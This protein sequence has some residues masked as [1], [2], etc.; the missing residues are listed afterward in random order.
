[1]T[2]DDTARHPGIRQRLVAILAADAAGYSRRMSEDEHG[3]LDALEAARSVFRTA[4]EG[5]NGRVIDTAGDSVLAVFET[6]K[7]ALAAAIAVQDDLSARGQGSL[8]FRVGV[9]LGDVIQKPDGT[10]YGDGVNVA[11]R[12]QAL[13]D[14]GSVLVSDLVY[15][16]LRG[17]MGAS[18]V[19]H[20]THRVKNIERPITAFRVRTAG[21][22]TERPVSEVA[23]AARPSVAV[24]PFDNMSG[25]ERETYM[26]DGLTEDLIAA[27]S[28]YRGL[29][30]IARN[31]CFA[32]KGR[33]VDV[34][35]AAKELGA[36]YV[37]E[38][39]VRKS[40]TRLRVVAQLIEG[41]SGDHL[42]A[43]RYDREL[44]DLFALQDDIV[45]MI[46][47]RLEPEVATVELQRAMR[48]PTQNLGA[49]DCY[50][51]ALSQLYRFTPDANA[52]A[53]RLFR[54]AIEF[55]ANFA[56]AHA[57]LAYCLILDMVY[58]DAPA[59]PDVL[60]EILS[61]TKKAVSLDPSDAF[62]HLA[63][64][65]AHIAR[66]EYE[67]GLA[68]C[69]A[70][71]RLNPSMGIAYCGMGDALAYAGRAQDAIE[72]FETAIRLSPNDPWRWAFYAYG[73]LTLIF[74]RRF[75]HAA[76]WAQKALLV[77]NCQYW[78]SA[79]LAVAL[80]HLGRQAEARAALANLKKMHPDFSLPYAREQ[81]F[82][83]ERAEQIELYLDGLRRAGMTG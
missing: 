71:L 75:D 46:A 78:A 13:A 9:H 26:A 45:G 82:Y 67:L 11:A 15:G 72:C 7:G 40:G 12:L 47:G 68:A 3:T 41:A 48:K 36:Q 28:K 32:Y 74:L 8:H 54:R 49:W 20:G 64:G 34:R 73:A 62:C 81:L 1:M 39:S 69:E 80:G 24:L 57:R 59:T 55:D 2:A 76:E 23:P 29:R 19:E 37:L 6:A 44:Q 53:E 70:G 25:D 66:R 31:S 21:E 14:P 60:D 43:E 42:W 65:R 18:F 22:L 30:V 33:A 5:N 27:L 10:I 50:H 52:E 77:P 61:L 56:L 35:Q 58:Y 51:L 4:I 83:L 63:L 16:A 17:K 38:G 79:H